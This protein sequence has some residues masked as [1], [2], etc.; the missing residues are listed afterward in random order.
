VRLTIADGKATNITIRGK[1][2]DPTKTYTIAMPDYVA[3]GGDQM[4]A[5]L[6]ASSR[7]DYPLTIRDMIIQHIEQLAT[8]G[9]ALPPS[10]SGRITIR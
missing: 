8:Q 1:A 6:N 4:E 5:C 3:N 2:I 9:K 7:T 10:T